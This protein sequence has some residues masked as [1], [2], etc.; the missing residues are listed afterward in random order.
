MTKNRRKLKVEKV[1]NTGNFKDLSDVFG[2]VLKED[3]LSSNKKN[4]NAIL[5]DAM[6][7]IK[8]NEKKYFSFNEQELFLSVRKRWVDYQNEKN[9]IR[10]EINTGI[11]EIPLNNR[12]DFLILLLK[13]IKQGLGIGRIEKLLFLLGKEE[14][15]DKY[16]QN[17]YNHYA[18]S[19][20]PFDKL[21]YQDIEV[22]TQFGLISTVNPIENSDT[23]NKVKV[24][25]YYK[26]TDK[27]EKFAEAL[28][29]AANRKDEEILKKIEHIKSKYKDM[30]WGK[31]L[32][33][34]Y[35]TYPE[36]AKNSLI[37]DE[38]F[39]SDDDED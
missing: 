3:F 10:E 2:A 7:Q 25:K 29:K 34:V 33:Y 35:S 20:G 24:K 18:Y 26:L 28:T 23:V 19:Y 5:E 36:Y 21:V 11:A 38:V 31:L 13:V 37:K 6:D 32:K 22:L 16:V 17:Y 15:I 8:I 1:K 12:P 27:G 9:R 14:Q 30:K 39:G 4:M